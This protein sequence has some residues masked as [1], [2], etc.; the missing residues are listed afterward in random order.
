[1]KNLLKQ[2]AVITILFGTAMFAINMIFGIGTTGFIETATTNGITY[3]K[4][5]ILGYVR[6]LQTSFTDIAVL[7]LKI[8]ETQW[9]LDVVNDLKFMVNWF[10][11]YLNL[12]LYPIRISAYLGRFWLSVIGVNVYSDTGGLAWLVQTIKVLVNLQIPYI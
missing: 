6:N 8:P 7:Q 12:F 5:D 2:I 11:L 10:F 9:N 1:M 4:F 3:Q